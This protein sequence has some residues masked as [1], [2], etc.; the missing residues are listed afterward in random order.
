MTTMI[1]ALRGT[2]VWGGYRVWQRNRD[3]FLRAWVLDTGGLVVE[4]FFIVLAMAF[5]LGLYIDNIDGLSYGN[6]VAPGILAGYAMYHSSFDQTFGAYL[7]LETHHI[8]D[9]ILFTPLG[10]S[11]IVLGEILW[12]STRSI[13]SGTAV[14]VVAAI[15]GLIGSPLAILAL[16][17]AWLIGLTFACIGM[18]ITAS[19]KSLGAIEN[20]F[21]VILTPLFMF[22]GIFFPLDQLPV[23]VQVVS[24]LLPLTPGVELI[25]AL[26]TGDTS[27][28]MALWAL[29]LVGYSAVFYLLA[30][31]LM[32]KRLIK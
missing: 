13:M 29:E 31:R 27:G 24:W 28:W 2:V 23:G 32:R 3:V 25:R 4:P 9:A 17:V 26:F 5:G 10:P 7:R 19:V 12:G 18:T 14:L 11:D 20:Y 6:F 21:T 8:Y 30:T 16:P 15:F 1:S 22:S